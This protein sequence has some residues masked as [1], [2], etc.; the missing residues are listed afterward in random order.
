VSGDAD[1]EPTARPTISVI[2]PAFNE[3]SVLPHTLALVRRAVAR[4]AHNSVEVCVVDNRSTDRTA[5]IAATA[6]ARVV[7]ERSVGIS[8]ARNAGAAAARGSLLVFIDADAEFEDRL[9]ARIEREM[10]DASCVGGAADAPYQRARKR[11]VR[12]YLGAWHV[13]GRALRMSQGAVQFCRDDVFRDL[14][15]YATGQ[16][17]GE[18]V[19]FIWRMRRHAKRHGHRVVVIS[20]VEVR[21]SA[22]RF[23]QWPLWRTLV[24]TNPL[25]IAVLRGRPGPWRE[26][27]ERPPR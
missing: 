27:Y 7:P 11:L 6:G 8:H 16:Y 24:W 18:D 19:D 15:G 4:L 5:E 20:D 2:V 22:R 17:M 9:L 21:Q 10:E 3:E 12:V 26:W 25:L 13:V 23:D 1:A 14:G